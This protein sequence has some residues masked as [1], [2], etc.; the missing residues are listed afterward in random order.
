MGLEEKPV[1]GTKNLDAPAF[2]NALESVINYKGDNYYKACGH[3]VR[4]TEHG[5]TSCVKRAGH[6]SAEHED[7]YGV[8]TDAS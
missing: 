5:T 7:F 8:T 3:I 6:P 1:E 2:T 4:Q